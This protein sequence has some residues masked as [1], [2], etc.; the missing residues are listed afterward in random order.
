MRMSDWS[1]DVCSSDLMSEREQEGEGGYRPDFQRQPCVEWQEGAQR[2]IEERHEGEKERPVTRQL[3]PALVR[4][5]V[6]G[7]LQQTV[8]QGI[9]LS[10]PTEKHQSKKGV[11]HCR[12]SEVQ[13][14]ALQSLMRTS[15]AVS[16]LQT[17][18]LSIQLRYSS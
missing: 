3:Q 6:V 13:T 18:L 8:E 12:R 10:Q 16:C 15:Y 7:C 1:S 5:A 14:S 9:F 2:F 17:T 11:Y 4:K